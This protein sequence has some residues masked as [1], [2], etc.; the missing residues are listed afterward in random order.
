M[1]RPGAPWQICTRGVVREREESVGLEVGRWPLL[2]M[3]ILH[4]WSIVSVI[5]GRWLVRSSGLLDRRI[6]RMPAVF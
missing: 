6:V 5:R 3:L 1:S 2:V 4:K